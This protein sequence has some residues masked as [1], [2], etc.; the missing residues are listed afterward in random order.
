MPPSLNEE[1]AWI[2]EHSRWVRERGNP[3]SRK[4]ALPRFKDCANCPERAQCDTEDERR[5]LCGSC[6]YGDLP[7]GPSERA[8]FAMELA[9]LPVALLT[10][11]PGALTYQQWQDVETARNRMRGGLF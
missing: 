6:P 8:L 2:E 10:A 4:P 7:P 11:D 1:I 9:S 5:M 3:P